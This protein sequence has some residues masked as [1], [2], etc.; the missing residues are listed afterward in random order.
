MDLMKLMPIELSYLWM[1]AVQF[2]DV[3]FIALTFEINRI[4]SIVFVYLLYCILLH[5]IALNRKLLC[6]T[7]DIVD[8]QFE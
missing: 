1:I 3:L 6:F 4:M 8:T 5:C 7:E 2:V